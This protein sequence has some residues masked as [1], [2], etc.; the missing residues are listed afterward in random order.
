[1]K[2]NVEATTGDGVSSQ[3]V[4]G[5]SMVQTTKHQT[6]DIPT[7]VDMIQL[8]LIEIHLLVIC[9][10]SLYRVRRYLSVTAIYDDEIKEQSAPVASSP[11]T[12]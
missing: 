5:G 9:N 3:I 2:L 1:M 6:T 11:V 10:A 8:F 7:M 12:W 4:G